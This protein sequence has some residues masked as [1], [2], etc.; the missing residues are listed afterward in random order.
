M[1]DPSTV[2]EDEELVLH[3]SNGLTYQVE[4]ISVN[5]LRPPDMIF[6]VNLIDPE[7]HSYYTETGDY[8]FCG[9]DFIRKCDRKES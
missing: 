7:G 8:H 1:V 6:A 5:T 4:V 3:S 2:K 9:E